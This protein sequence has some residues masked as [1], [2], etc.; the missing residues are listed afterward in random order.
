MDYIKAA[1]L[2]DIDRLKKIYDSGYKPR[3]FEIEVVVR[4]A[5]LNN[6][7]DVLYLL[8]E[9]HCICMGVES[10]KITNE[11]SKMIFD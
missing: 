7:Y 2:G 10:I 11:A 6:D 9:K 5:R 3:W 4:Y 8:E 1:A